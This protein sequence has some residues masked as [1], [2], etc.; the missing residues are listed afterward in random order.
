MCKDDMAAIRFSQT[1]NTLNLKA[2]Y[3][4]V[5][6]AREG[7]EVSCIKGGDVQV[8]LRPIFLRDALYA[9]DA[10]EVNIYYQSNRH[11]V[12]LQDPE[13]PGY[14]CVVMPITTQARVE[15][16][17]VAAMARQGWAAEET[18]TLIRYYD[19]GS[20]RVQA[21]LLK[22]GYSRSR[23][24]IISKAAYMRRN[25]EEP[26]DLSPTR[27]IVRWIHQAVVRWFAYYR[28]LGVDEIAEAMNRPREVIEELLGW[29]RERWFRMGA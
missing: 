8:A 25:E 12:L 9:M 16:R 14:S 2:A 24:S 13:D 19:Y 1:D 15:I 10:D 17:E 3:V 26:M 7:D 23:A 27:A 28:G 20:Q 22:L 5:G 4:E 29:R 18:D 21:E 6:E 11:P